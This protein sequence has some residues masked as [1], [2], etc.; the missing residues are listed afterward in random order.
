MS[1][2][3]KNLWPNFYVVY[4]MICIN[5]RKNEEN[6]YSKKTLFREVEIFSEVK[7]ALFVGVQCCKVFQRKEWD[8]LKRK[9]FFFWIK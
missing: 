8:F 6:G 5:E 1:D 3:R 9:C 4:K 7:M 2:N